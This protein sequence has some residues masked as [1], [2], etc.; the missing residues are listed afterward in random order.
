MALGPPPCLTMWRNPRVF[1]FS[2]GFSRDSR[3]AV[4]EPEERALIV[5]VLSPVF[6]SST[7]SARAAAVL[8]FVASAV[9]HHQHA[10]FAARRRAL[11]R[12]CRLCGIYFPARRHLRCQNSRSGNSGAFPMSAASIQLQIVSGNKSSA[13]PPRDVIQHR[14]NKSNIRICGDTRWFEPCVQ[15]LVHEYLQRH[16]ILQAQ[17]NGQ[18]QTVHHAGK[19][20][21]F[22]GHLHED[23]ARPAVLIHPNGD[24]AFVP[25]HAELVRSEEHTSELQSRLHLVCRLLL[26]KKKKK[27]SSNNNDKQTYNIYR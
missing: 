15:Q 23:L 5:G 12:V 8:A 1:G 22:L 10:A 11:V 4:P 3:A 7:A 2:G 20:R 6:R 16:A 27:K 13:H 17:R 19:R 26:E 18:R 21:A 24:V 9:R 14:R 25:P